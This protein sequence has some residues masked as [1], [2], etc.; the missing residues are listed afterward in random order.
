MALGRNTG[1]PNQVAASQQ[2]TDQ[3]DSVRAALVHVVRRRA[4]TSAEAVAQGDAALL[5][6]TQA[7]QAHL[8]DHPTCPRAQQLAA[9]ARRVTIGTT[10]TADLAILDALPADA[11]ATLGM[12][13]GR[14][15]VWLQNA[16]RQN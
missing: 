3:H 11:L 16:Q 1:M 4:G 12:K 14:F 15:V 9:L 7:L 5:H 13:P 6:L 8:P 2:L 10:S